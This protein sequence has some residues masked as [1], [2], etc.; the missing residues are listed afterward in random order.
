MNIRI[1]EERWGVNHRTG[2]RSS[3]QTDEKV[4]EPVVGATLNMP[5]GRRKFIVDAADD[6]AVT[7]TVH[8][9]NNP[10]ADKSW[11]INKGESIYYR[12]MSVDGGYKYT[13]SYEDE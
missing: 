12:P 10:S 2:S 13:I 7:I 4:F 1:V 3:S 11:T 8:Y 9:E 6:I 5:I